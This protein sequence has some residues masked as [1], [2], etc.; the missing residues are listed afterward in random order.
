MVTG[1]EAGGGQRLTAAL[2]AARRTLW[3]LIAEELIAFRTA[4]LSQ[5]FAAPASRAAS[6]EDKR[7]S[8]GAGLTIS[9][10]ARD[11]GDEDE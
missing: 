8:S 9:T 11:D 6:K 7:A 2:G 1:R 3:R 5:V 10:D 4:Q